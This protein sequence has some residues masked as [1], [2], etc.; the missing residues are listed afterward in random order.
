[1]RRLIYTF[2]V[3]IWLKQ[4]F[5]WRGS[6]VYI[7]TS[8]NLKYLPCWI[9]KTVW[10]HENQNTEQTQYRFVFYRRNEIQKWSWAYR[11]F[12]LLDCRL[13][14]YPYGQ[15]VHLSYDIY[16][17]PVAFSEL[18]DLALSRCIYVDQ[19]YCVKVANKSYSIEGGGKCLNHETVDDVMIFSCHYTC[20]ET[21]SC[22]IL[23]EDTSYLDRKLTIT[24]SR[25]SWSKYYRDFIHGR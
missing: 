25:Q 1:M 16:F 18:H 8:A 14:I 5:S 20:H 3:R 9:W 17:Y 24:K 7:S 21:N 23:P 15:L 10:A 2:V 12:I 4:V 22:T 6:V 19:T 13:E 11:I